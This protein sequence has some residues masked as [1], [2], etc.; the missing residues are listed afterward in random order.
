MFSSNLI[1]FFL[2]SALLSCQAC[3][4][5]QSKTDATVSPT[6]FI[7][8][9]LKSE[10]P[11][12]TKEPDAFQTE[13]VVTA[14]DNFE[15]K[16]FIAKNGANRFIAF[17]FQ[18]KTEFALL[19]L[20][21]NQSFLIA[22]SQKVFA[23]NQLETAGAESETLNDLLTAGWSNQKADAKFERLGAE[24]NFVKYLVSLDETKK[25]EIII[26]VDEKIGLPVKQEFYSMSNGQKTLTLT[27]EIKNFSLQTEAKY[28][29]V[30][31]D[32]KKVLLKEFWETLRR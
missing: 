17:D 8:E 24:N 27:M 26:S 7:V 3:G 18:G 20:G 23:E 5:C 19:Q 16:T 31:K 14:K 10:I 21:G 2:V 15:D 11:F 6:P 9:E 25:S 12:L 28:F 4:F 22:P 29:E 30:P 1:K 32:Y 13:I